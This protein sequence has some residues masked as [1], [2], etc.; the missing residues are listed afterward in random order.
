MATEMRKRVFSGIQPSGDLHIGNYIGAVRNWVRMQDERDCHFGIVDLHAISIWQDPAELHS[1]SRQVAMLLMAC[2]IDPDK[3]KLFIQSHIP[4]HAELCW[5]LNCVTPVS[6]LQRMTQYKSKSEAQKETASTGLLDYPVLQAADI[7]IYQ[8]HYVPVGEDQRQHVELTRDIA[9]RFNNLYGET[10]IIP[11]VELPP[12]GARIMGLDDPTVKMSKSIAEQS[13]GHALRLLDPPD[14][15]RKKIRK[16]VTDPGT[17]IKFDPSRPGVT[18]LLTIYQVCT[19]QEQ[20][21]IEAYF[22]GKG[23]AALKREVAEAVIEF[24]RPVR[25]RYAKLEAEPGYVE[26]VLRRGAEK[27]RPRAIQT[28]QTAKDRMGVG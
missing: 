8:S 3:G 11:Q 23:Y 5:L 21:D 9:R 1:S 26:G 20:A 6:W 17:E 24:L 7:L 22:E 12:L 4:E 27:A 14:V 25:E 28:L 10:F 2:G 16:A 19:E 18:N 13:K 15:L